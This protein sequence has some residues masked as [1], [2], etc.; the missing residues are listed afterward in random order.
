MQCCVIVVPSPLFSFAIVIGHCYAFVL[1]WIC[2]CSF[3]LLLVLCYPFAL[4]Y[5]CFVVVLSTTCTMILS[6]VF[7]VI[8]FSHY[9]CSMWLA[10]IS[11]PSTC[12]RNCECGVQLTSWVKTHSKEPQALLWIET[13]CHFSLK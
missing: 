6:I 1:L 11:P 3:M 2:C 10:S 9:S 4:L 8:V 12:V 5:Y 7:I 13:T